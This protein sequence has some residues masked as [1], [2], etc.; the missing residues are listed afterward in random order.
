MSVKNVGAQKQKLNLGIF[1]SHF[2][3]KN[4]LT[5]IHIFVAFFIYSGE[6]LA[7]TFEKI[8]TFVNHKSKICFLN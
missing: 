8:E 3:V 5:V 4:R 2:C 6:V 1:S 7:V